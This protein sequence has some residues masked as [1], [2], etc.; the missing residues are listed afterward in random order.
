[1]Q[2]QSVLQLNNMQNIFTQRAGLV[3]GASVLSAS[4]VLLTSCHKLGD[5]LPTH[6]HSDKDFGNFKQINLVANNDSYGASR[7]DPK[8]LNAWGIAFGG[9]GAAWVASAGGGV[10]TV[11]DS[12][13]LD[14]IPAVNI[15]S[16]A[17]ATGGTPTG[18]VLNP[19]SVDFAL[20]NG[21]PARFIF[22]NLDGV[23]SGWNGGANAELIK[24][25][26]G[27][28]VY[29]GAAL[30][31]YQGHNFLYAANAI[32]GIIEVYD[33][34]FTV[35]STKKF[36]DPNLPIGYAPFNVSKIGEELFV[37]YTKVGPDGRAVKEVGNGVVNVF[38]TGG[39]FKRRFAYG[40]K[41]N[42]PWG[43]A[44]ASPEFFGGDN[45]Q[46]AILV[47][48]FGDGKINVYKPNG[49]FID[50]L[51][52]N[53]KVVEI[54]GLWAIVFPPAGTTIDPHRLYFAAGPDD[55]KDGL[56]GYLVK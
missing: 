15:P 19:S 35:D 30:A 25:N 51:K 22:V 54:E 37:A 10:S 12:A 18:V 7:I 3:R 56:F 38:S 6:G 50:Q 55:E 20:S 45:A 27:Q 24:N 23:I 21:K 44:A 2:H 29:T 31:E 41:L 1:V 43:F 40:G 8:L 5:Y 53:N 42:A 11:Y 34:S 47:G 13:G 49:K 52:V 14:L 26:V 28:S 33:A 4:L 16:P 32:K 48:N 9:N 39:E 46:S 36:I 17:G